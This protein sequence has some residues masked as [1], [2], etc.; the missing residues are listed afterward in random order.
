MDL[1][2]GVLDGS[3]FMHVTYR[4]R[5]PI[6]PAG[7]LHVYLDGDGSPW[8]NRYTIAPDPTP[9]KPLA[10]ALMA[11]DTDASLYLGRPCYHGMATAPRCHAAIWTSRRYGPEALDSLEA[12]LRRY[13]QGLTPVRL[14]FI[15]YSGGGTL[16]LL[17]AERFPETAGVVTVAGNLDPTSWTTYHG[18]SPLIGSLN[19]NT[20]PPLNQEVYQ[21]H[22]LGTDD[23]LVPPSLSAPAAEAGRLR[24]RVLIAGFDHVCCWVEAWPRLLAS[25]REGL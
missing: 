24:G 12:A 5:V 14:V 1:E 18:Y 17:L 9:R 16:A 3:G 2:R 13:L 23:R 4:N 11:Q 20:R 15:G 8:L 19:P 25:V 6:D 21:R 7:I 10:L 22:F